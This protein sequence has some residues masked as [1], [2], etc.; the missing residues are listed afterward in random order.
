MPVRDRPTQGDA[1]TYRVIQWSTGNVGQYALR[2]VADHPDLELVGLWVHGADKAGTRRGRAR[3]VRADGRARDQR[4]RRAARARRRL[5]LLHRD[6]R[7]AGRPRR[8]RT[9]RASSRRARTSCRARSCRS[10]TRRTSRPRCASRSRTRAPKRACRSSPRGS[11][12]GWANDLLPLVLTGTLRVHR[13]A[14][15]DGG[16]QLR[17]LRAA[18]G[19][20]RDDGLRQAARR[21]AAAA[22][23]R[24]CSRS[25]GAAR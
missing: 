19:A 3:R 11:I 17:D 7:S 10:S 14:A 6:R 25:R 13:V 8:S 5:R 1:V 9:W 24:A 20:L 18:A 15:R 16:R 4:R 12:P 23:R 2:L 22:A 21:D